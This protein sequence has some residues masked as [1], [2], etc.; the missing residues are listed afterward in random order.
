M[1]LR[2]PI[3]V[4]LVRPLAAILLA[5]L[6]PSSSPPAS[7]GD[8]SAPT[9]PA[10]ARLVVVERVLAQDQGDWQVDYAFRLDADAP[11]TLTPSD[12]TARVEGWLS[13]SR[14][15]VHATPRRSAAMLE[16]SAGSTAFAD[17]ITSAE[18][19]Q[20]C[21]ERVVVRLDAGPIPAQAPARPR[22]SDP[23]PL[24][25]VTIAPGGT[26]RVRLR[27]EHQ[28]D[29]FGD[30][31]PL[32]GRRELELHLG[33]TAF[34]DNLPLDRE[35]YLAQPR[36]TWGEPA[37]DRKDSRM[38]L[39]GPDSLH[40]EADVPG[41]QYYRFPERKVRYGTRMRLRYSYFIAHGT[42]GEFRAR[43]AQYRESTSAWKPLVEGASEQTLRT[44]GRWVKVEKVFRTELEA[45]TLALDFRI[46]T[47][48]AEIGEVWIDDVSLEPVDAPP[49]G[50]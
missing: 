44:V 14:V 35:Q 28:H 19:C 42:E 2:P 7:A 38:A 46:V 13:N 16:G 30:Y 26:L 32:L 33:A 12:V 48:N 40:L 43:I 1:K 50:P 23:E 3:G 37:E 34:R 36:D 15:P 8:I 20:R 10:T 39:S 22:G 17:I 5:A 6:A 47:P 24:A 11:M 49:G 21:R 29:L 9:S 45:T 4:R 41:N 27:L 25:P 31:D 18:E